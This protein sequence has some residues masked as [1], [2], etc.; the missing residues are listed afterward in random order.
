MK[1]KLGSVRIKLIL[2]KA[3]SLDRNMFG[4]Q[5]ASDGAHTQSGSSQFKLEFFLFR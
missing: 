3:L 5:F 2:R 4:F 1:I